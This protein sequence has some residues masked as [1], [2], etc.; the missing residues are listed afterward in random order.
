MKLLLSFIALATLNA[1]AYQP[2]I[3]SL[4]RN[5]SNGAIGKNT[6]AGTFILKRK[7]K[8]DEDDETLKT[9]PSVFTYKLLF[10]NDTE[11]AKLA[12]VS[13]VGDVASGNT[14][15]DV[16]FFPNTGYTSMRLGPEDSEKKFFYALMSSLLN[17]D[18]ALM[19]KF[20]NDLGVDAKVNTERADKEQL[21][22]LGKYV[23]YLKKEDEERATIENPLTP[24]D[25]DEKEKLKEV[26]KRPFLTASP[27]VKR[28]KEG[29]EF[30]WVAESEKFMAKFSHDEHKLLE[31]II[32]TDKGEIGVKCFN[33]IL[34]GKD[35]QF[36]ELV[37]LKDL[38]GNEYMLNMKK[39]SNFAEPYGDFTDRLGD[40]KKALNKSNSSNSQIKPSFTL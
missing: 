34:Y 2:T 18:G 19:I 14:I 40:Y 37:I 35:M 33:Y 38:A 8:E 28:T 27:F 10:A 1:F 32:R 20:L 23:Q 6:V 39:I 12:Q 30:F 36:P 13:Y 7:V 26:F 29:S 9:L 22:Y 21:Y 5:G 24:S 17:N 25:V 16:R 3:E 31:M 15:S 4:F 11:K